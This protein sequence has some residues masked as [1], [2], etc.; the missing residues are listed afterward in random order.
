MRATSEVY[1][2]RPLE[3]A[4]YLALPV[5]CVLVGM[6]RPAYV[7]DMAS[8]GMVRP[9]PGVGPGKVDADALVAAFRRRAQH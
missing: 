4:E 2:L 3:D 1:E 7:H 5:T 9:K 6:R 8:L